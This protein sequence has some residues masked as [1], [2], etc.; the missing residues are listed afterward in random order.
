MTLET[1]NSIVIIVLFV[2]LVATLL[3]KKYIKNKR[4]SFVIENSILLKEID[5][6]N[7][8]YN[9]ETVYDGEYHHKCNSKSEFDRKKFDDIALDFVH[10]NLSQLQEQIRRVYYNI[11][12]ESLY[13]N[14]LRIAIQEARRKQSFLYNNYKF[15]YQIE[16]DMIENKLL[17]IDLEIFLIIKKSYTSPQGRNYYYDKKVY[18]TIEIKK[19]IEKDQER[20]IVNESIK[21]ER[22]LMTDSL[23]YD[24]LKR[25]G[26]KCQICG[27]TQEDGVKLHVD[28]IKPVSKGGR[29][30]P[31]N[32]RTLC[33]RCNMGKSAKYD[34]N[35]I[36]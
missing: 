9:F 35:G 23:R 16:E 5:N 6:I 28:H 20:K 8:N 32:L 18:K 2:I 1:K 12:L 36:N 3:I 26:F 19:L 15:F 22:S 31:S 21:Y 13:N 24:I 7:R 10:H 4:E 11:N 14:A 34:K 17:E 33:D 27:A 25:D 30:V 29:T